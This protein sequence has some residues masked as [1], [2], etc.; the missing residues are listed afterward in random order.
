MIGRAWDIK[1]WLQEIAERL[2][3]SNLGMKWGTPVINLPVVQEERTR[4]YTLKYSRDRRY[5][6]ECF[7]ASKSLKPH[8][9][10]FGIVANFIHSLD[11]THML[12]TVEDLVHEKGI[13]SIATVHDSFGVHAANVD[14]LCD[15]LRRN[16]QLIHEKNL[17]DEFWSGPLT[18]HPETLND[19]GPPPRALDG[20]HTWKPE[21]I[22]DSI[23]CF[24]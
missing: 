2:A 6:F 20:E 7:D 13:K 1:G 14:A 16:F 22:L 5:V 11:A 17:L 12:L 23:Y 8:R 15:S 19:I 4:R 18:N 9:A 3:R 10:K 24:S 21:E